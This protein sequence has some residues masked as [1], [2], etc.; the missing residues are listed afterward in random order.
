MD[1][2]EVEAAFAEG[3]PVPVWIGDDRFPVGD[4]GHPMTDA[5]L[6]LTILAADSRAADFLR[7]AGVDEAAVRTFRQRGST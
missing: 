5:R 1:E 6:L 4:V 3:A 2:H 7:A